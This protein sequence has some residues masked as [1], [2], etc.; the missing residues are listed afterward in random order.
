MMYIFGAV[1]ICLS[2]YFSNIPIVCIAYIIASVISI[3]FGMLNSFAMRSYV[4]K[5]VEMKE[6]N[7]DVIEKINSRCL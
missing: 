3:I 4:S 2:V 5:T 6:E 7:K 1:F